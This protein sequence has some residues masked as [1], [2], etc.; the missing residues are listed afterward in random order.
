MPVFNNQKRSFAFLINC[1]Y[2]VELLYFLYRNK[3]TGKRSYLPSSNTLVLHFMSTTRSYETASGAKKKKKTLNKQ[4][5]RLA[6][7]RT[8]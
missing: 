8:F 6:T 2:A 1:S 3:R 5:R 7:T 4:Y